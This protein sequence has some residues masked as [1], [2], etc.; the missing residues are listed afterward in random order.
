M[1]ALIA[2]ST[3]SITA[4]WPAARLLGSILPGEELGRGSG[5]SAAWSSWNCRARACPGWAK[6]TPRGGDR[7]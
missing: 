5:F 2:R 6:G 7:K 1:A 3:A 4:A